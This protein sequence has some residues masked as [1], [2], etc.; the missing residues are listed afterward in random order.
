MNAPSP[1]VSPSP[2]TSSA[3]PGRSAALARA[4]LRAETRR[5][6]RTTRWPILTG[7][8]AV[9]AGALQAV[10]AGAVL[11]R[12]LAALAAALHPPPPIRFP[13]AGAPAAPAIPALG[14][15]AYGQAA[16]GL[17]PPPPP[18]TALWVLLG[19]FLLAMLV[20]AAANYASERF[21]FAAGA[22]AR[23]HLRSDAMARLLAAG[24]AV[25]AGQH[26][27]ALAAIVMDRIELLDGY[28]ARYLPARTL[29]LVGPALILLVALA[30]DPF[31]ALVLA[32][33]GALVPFGM[34][35]AGIGAKRATERQFA[36]LSRLQVRFLDRM[37][38]LSTIIL[39][40]RAEAEAA[41]LQTAAGDLRRRTMRVLRVA[42]LSASILDLAAA[43][44]LVVLAIH[45]AQVLAP[46]GA[47]AK[48]V[49]PAAALGVLLLVAEF[50][51]P[52]RSLA[53]VYQDGIHARSAAAELIALP[54]APPEPVA[55]TVRNVAAQGISVA[56][57][58]VNLTRDAARGAVLSD[59]S[60]RIPAGETLV[61]V[62][63]SGSGKS[64]VI[65]TLL[66]FHRPQ[67][68]RVTLNGADLSDVV[69]AALSR[70]TAWVGQR[71][72]LF[73]GTIAENIRFARPEASEQEVTAAARAA[74][75]SDFA[76]AL[77]AGLGTRIGEGGF[78]LSGGQAQRIAIARA[79]LRNAPLLLLDEPTAHLDPASEALVLDSLRRLAVGRTVILASHSA[80]AYEF[81]GR[82]LHLAA[83]RVAA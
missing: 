52:L 34:A 22:T 45:Y 55:R 73:A 64:T 56:F 28:F 31:A 36:A 53:S 30:L 75:V 5:A 72:K 76:E 23:R 78:G 69:P 8:V 21:A 67:S 16:A 25:L 47:P 2:A 74:H 44:A 41:A 13:L 80:A 66:G 79:F 15:T 9:A 35:L 63:P 61:L 1:P 29:A 46:A 68:G 32:L 17:P 54:P 65:E 70:L 7:L 77:P 50:F 49:A 19:G 33:A 60:F 58:H 26:S 24:P 37:R 62:G 43:A 6:G 18:H 48:G 39:A 71:P 4:W 11:A 14:I 59:L 12:A 3:E 83:G 57:E 10:L 40:G 51:A 42:F 81:S 82:R 20:R 38:G 27:G